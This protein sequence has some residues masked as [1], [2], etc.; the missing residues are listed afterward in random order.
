[1]PKQKSLNEIQE[2]KQ[3]PHQDPS[4]FLERLYQAY[5]HYTRAQPEAHEHV[6]G[7]NT[8]FVGQSAPDARRKLQKLDGTFGRSLSLLVEIALRYSTRNSAETS[9]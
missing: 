3:K 1:M 6:R 8:T 9:R 7:I 2:L 5:S 4:E